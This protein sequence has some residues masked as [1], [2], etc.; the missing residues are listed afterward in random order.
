VAGKTVKAGALLMALVC[1]AAAGNASA[2]VYKWKDAKGVTHFSDTPPPPSAAQVE[3]KSY[4]GGG[5]SVELPYELAQAVKNFPVVFYTTKDCSACDQGRGWLRGRGI[6]FTEKTV[7]S[8]DDQAALK[9]AG[10]GN[11]LPLLMVGRSQLTGFEAGAWDG[12]LASASYP[13][14]RVLP[15]NYQFPAPTP[16][17][18]PRQ[19]TAVA[20]PAAPAEAP[21]QR[22]APVNAPPDFQF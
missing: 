2:Q 3:V 17:A 10:G 16:A 8:A 21:A 14:E 22:P 6:P 11:Q 4:A 18:P 5:A 19:A 15:A 9:R 12:A 13:A 1:L 7:N 20:K